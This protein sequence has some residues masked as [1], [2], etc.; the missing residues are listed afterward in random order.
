MQLK[1]RFESFKIKEKHELLKDDTGA[2]FSLT[3]IQV[4]LPQ[5]KYEI[6]I[7]PYEYW[8]VIND[9]MDIWSDKTTI[10]FGSYAFWK[11][12]KRENL[13]QKT[14][15][16]VKIKEVLSGEHYIFCNKKMPKRKDG[17]FGVKTTFEISIDNCKTE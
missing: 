12:S 9:K 4:Y 13:I 2:T 14:I 1:P 16:G 11:D 17:D 7:S 8:C 15:C 6:A 3:K 10:S 5:N